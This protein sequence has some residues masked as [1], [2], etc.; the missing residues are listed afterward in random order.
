M[1]RTLILFATALALIGTIPPCTMS[2]S[3]GAVTRSRAGLEHCDLYRIHSDD[4]K[5]W[6]GT[7]AESNSLPAGDLEAYIPTWFVTED[8]VRTLDERHIG[9]LALTDSTGPGELKALANSKIKSVDLHPLATVTPVSMVPP[10]KTLESLSL[11][12]ENDNEVAD[13]GRFPNLKKF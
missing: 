10:M 8:V 11:H 4:Q 3:P 9:S 5:E 13:L 2:A 6:V 1:Y 7:L 12:T